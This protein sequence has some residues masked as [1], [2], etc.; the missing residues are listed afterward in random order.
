MSTFELLLEAVKAS[1]TDPNAF[2]AANPAFAALCTQISEAEQLIKG[3]NTLIAE[4]GSQ[5]QEKFIKRRAAF[6]AKRAK[7]FIRRLRKAG[8]NMQSSLIVLQGS[9]QE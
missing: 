2:D 1:A 7:E 6:V 5:K 9:R 8:E 4:H 3:M